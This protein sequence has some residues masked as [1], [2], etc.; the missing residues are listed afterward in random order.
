MA[1][2]FKAKLTSLALVTLAFACFCVGQTAPPSHSQLTGT[3]RGTIVD[4]TG[5]M[6]PG[7]RVKLS[8]P[9]QAAT[10][11]TLS[12]ADGKFSFAEVAPG[13]F[14]LAVTSEGFAAQT[15]AGI[16]PAG[17][18]Y[19]VPLISM[20]VAEAVTEVRVG[21]SRE[22]VAL[23][24]EQE[25]K[26]EEKQKVL[27]VIP[28]FYVSYVSHAAPLNSKQKFELAWKSTINPVN[29]V[30]VGGI[31]GIQQAA[32]DFKGYGQGAQGYAKRYG[33]SYAD[34]V[35][36]TFL[37]SA[38][39]PSVFK[40]DPRYFYKGTG[41]V[42][43]R[44]L[45]AIANAVICK[46]DDGRWQANYSGLLGGLAAGGISNLYYPSSDRNGLSLTFENTLIGIGSTAVTNVLQ[47]FVV[48]RF[49]HKLPS[50]EP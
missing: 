44:S 7:A 10:Q 27:G 35:V 15:A 23:V 17:E 40:Q 45:Y 43:S 22:E 25:I 18:T 41:S 21:L 36:G 31:A 24:A 39:L 50:P 48:R 4:Q 38:I 3:I 34:G 33:A 19:V 2:R 20:Q 37:G 28:N 14:Q 1:Q 29:F 47:E 30:I 49:T 9:G 16:L 8:R 42:R 46:G 26:E 13:P 11:E 12:G 6:V 5:A 32:D